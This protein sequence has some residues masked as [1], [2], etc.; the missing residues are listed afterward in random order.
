MASKRFL[1]VPEVSSAAR[2]P[3]PGATMACATLFNSVR[4]MLSSNAWHSTPIGT[5]PTGN[6]ARARAMKKLAVIRL[7]SRI[8]GV[9]GLASRR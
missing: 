7:T 4:F 1:M 5:G 2:M 9:E 6:A 3:R 8:S